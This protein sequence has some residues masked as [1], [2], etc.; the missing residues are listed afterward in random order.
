MIGFYRFVVQ[1]TSEASGHPNR[2]KKPF[3]YVGPDPTIEEQESEFWRIVEDPSEV[4][5]LHHQ[6]V[7]L[8]KVLVHIQTVGG[9]A[10]W[11]K[12]LGK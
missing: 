5:L 10:L 4:Y 3:Q 9:G 2:K 7:V 8:C 11:V 6:E 12:E 1:V